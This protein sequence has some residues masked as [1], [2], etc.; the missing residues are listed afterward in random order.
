VTHAGDG[1]PRGLYEARLRERRAAVA[2]LDARDLALSRA[3]LATA[4][5]ALVTWW[6]SV[7]PPRL[8]AAWLLLP[9]GL[10]AALMIA[11]VRL[12]E[13]RR[14][15]ARAVEFYARGLKRL[16][17]DLAGLGDTGG[18]FADEAHPYGADLDLFGPGSICQLLGG[19]R[20]RLGAQ[21]LAGLLLEPASAAEVRR[22]QAAVAQ[23]RP[24]LDLREDLFT[25]ESGPVTALDP[26]GLAAWGEAPARVAPRAV[27]ALALLLGLA[28]VASV[29]AYYGF[30]LAGH[31]AFVVL[32]SG[33][34]L[35]LALRARVA[36]IIRDVERPARELALLSAVLARL[37]RESFEPG[38]LLDLQRALTTDE[39]P[40]SRQLS[41]LSRLV[42]RL[43][44]R[45]NVLFAPLA[46]LLL[47][48]TRTALAID[49]W[50]AHCGPR[51]RDWAAAVGEMEAL[52]ALG[53][54]AFE[55]PR[56]PFP[57]IADE[58][59]LLDGEGLAHPLIPEARA[60]RNDLRL[61]A[62]RRLLIVS[63]SNMSGKSTLLRTVGVNVVLA[64]AGAPVRARRLRLSPLA[65]GTSL[66]VHDSLQ[67]GQSRFYAEITR[68]RLLVD[69]ARA[70]PPLLFL[71]DEI[72]HGTNS[73]DRRAGAEALLRGLLEHGAFGLVTTHD[74]ALAAIAEALAPR[75]ANVHFE[76]RLDEDGGGGMVFDY[77]LR[78]GV[79]ERSNA[80]ALMR[81][82]GLEV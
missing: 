75:A 56:D 38:P 21:R 51:L 22:R 7:A 27:R 66:H 68:L 60:V 5:A 82:V 61:D 19:A 11:H 20:T 9:L 31:V 67:A 70:R 74:L 45:R 30:G 41:R 57:E 43:E 14:A 62:A 13:R 80:L 10:F 55:H 39:L 44:S 32:A 4:A 72:L 73:S 3:R 29:A 8:S 35:A 12:S 40:P 28:N 69:L 54:Y 16:D 52:A 63:G 24:R 23:L 18:A 59:P 49:E 78:P 37:E 79:V 47:W 6:L 81:A 2:R 71:L 64:F 36:A 17:V 34:A 50:R 1:D 58:G 77:R 33:G 76:D 26:R 53:G 65:L 48:T 25:L 42:D 15:A 46:A